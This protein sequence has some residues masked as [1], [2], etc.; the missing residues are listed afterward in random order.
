LHPPAEQADGELRPDCQVVT[1]SKPTQ[2]E[3][4]AADQCLLLMSDVRERLSLLCHMVSPCSGLCPA[5]VGVCSD[6]AEEEQELAA[7]LPRQGILNNCS[8]SKEIGSWSKDFICG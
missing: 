6:S 2:E 3:A 7:H 5:G 4:E 8:R 1:G